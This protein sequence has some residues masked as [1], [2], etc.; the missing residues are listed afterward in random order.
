MS[1]KRDGCGWNL[2]KCSRVLYPFARVF[3]YSGCIAVTVFYFTFP[4]CSLDLTKTV[5]MIFCCQCI[6]QFNACTIQYTEHS[7]PFFMDLTPSRMGFF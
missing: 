5:Y 4:L 1:M 2:E 3:P 6:F 7:V